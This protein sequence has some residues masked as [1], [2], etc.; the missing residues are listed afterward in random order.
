MLRALVAG[1]VVVVVA[2]VPPPEPLRDTLRVFADFRRR[3]GLLHFLDFKITLTLG[4][5]IPQT[6][7]HYPASYVQSF[8]RGCS[9]S[10]G[11][12]K[13]CR[14]VIEQGERLYSFK[15]FFAIGES[16]KKPGSRY[17]REFLGLRKACS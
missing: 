10:G 1:A 9:S 12:A 11:T 6:N 5:G 3:G 16:N 4:G 17:Y 8:I 7:Y 13:Q 14:C 15:V 2:Q